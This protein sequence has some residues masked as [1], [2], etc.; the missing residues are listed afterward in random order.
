MEDSV[1]NGYLAIQGE[2]LFDL[3][4]PE[5]LGLHVN[6]GVLAAAVGAVGLEHIGRA[7]VGAGIAGAERLG[8]KGPEAMGVFDRDVRMLEDRLCRQFGRGFFSPRLEAAVAL[9]A[10]QGGRREEETK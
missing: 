4:D 9:A 8:M 7:G 6:R 3:I 2:L 5:A 10:G 1:V